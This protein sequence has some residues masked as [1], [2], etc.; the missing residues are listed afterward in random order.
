M[1][2]T[3]RSPAKALMF[4]LF[5]VGILI[6]ISGA[7]QLPKKETLKARQGTLQTK[8]KELKS[9]ASLQQKA[10][11]YELISESTLRNSQTVPKAIQKARLQEL[12]I[13]VK[14]SDAHRL[15]S[16]LHAELSALQ[17]R[18]A[19]LDGQ[20]AK[21][22]AQ[23]TKTALDTLLQS[24]LK[25]L[26][27]REK[28][29]KREAAQYLQRKKLRDEADRLKAKARTFLV[30]ALQ[31][32]ELKEKLRAD[33]ALLRA[34]AASL[35][36]RA[37][38]LSIEQQRSK[39]SQLQS[40]S[41]EYL[42]SAGKLDAANKL[43]Q[44]AAKLRAESFQV[45]S[46]IAKLQRKL[47]QLPQK[48]RQLYAQ[49]RDLPKQ[50]AKLRAKVAKNPNA[51]SKLYAKAQ[52]MRAKAKTLQKKY[53]ALLR[54]KQAN[55]VIASL[56]A[57][58]AKIEKARKAI[59]KDGGQWPDSVPIF[60]VGAFIA[61][62]GL[63]GWRYTN[64]Q[65]VKQRISKQQDDSA[66]P[67]A[68][69]AK[70]SHDIDAL[71]DDLKSLNEE[72]LCARVD[73]ILGESVLPFAEVRRGVIERLGMNDGAEILVVVAYAER[74]LNRVW[75]AASDGHLGEARSVLPDA[76]D[77]FRE[78]LALSQK[79]LGTPNTKTKTDDK[80]KTTAKKGS[81]KVDTTAKKD[82]EKVDAAAKKDAGK[83]D[84][85]AK[86]DADKADV[87]AKKGVDKADAAVKKD[88]D[89]ADDT[90]KKNDEKAGSF[91]KESDEKA[92]TSAKKD[93]PQSTDSDKTSP[94]KVAPA[95]AKKDTDKTSTEKKG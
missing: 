86:K 87:T 93:A 3:K 57:E 5:C 80:A 69:L 20:A 78:A 30:R 55:T 4:V 14:L 43:R 79:H 40:E 73:T 42:A 63:G 95:S 52:K 39:V 38:Q 12:Q 89:K 36:A 6:A 45:H 18:S 47:E 85:V 88:D 92:D 22:E 27:Q 32:P 16:R 11:K 37:L 61:L 82:T 58:V 44:Q 34:K 48:L 67:F 72:Q 70:A 28:I 62:A 74:M 84:A 41:K 19:R 77:A 51:A 54:N 9:I 21:L 53:T 50:L 75:S 8:I 76:R 59:P 31:V 17:A 7:A 35:R 25:Q 91:T 83:A 26:Q 71:F 94:D 66:G 1:A 23:A 24:R 56:Q 15:A 65:E 29:L 13:P 10:T 60:L 33:A 46:N 49:A 68:L 81:D 2:Q 64:R 90:A